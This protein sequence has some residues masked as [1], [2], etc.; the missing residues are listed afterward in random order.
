MRFEVKDVVDLEALARC[1]YRMMVASGSGARV[2]WE[3]DWWM[4]G[5]DEKENVSEGGRM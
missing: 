4:V 1:G 5:V 3:V 2:G